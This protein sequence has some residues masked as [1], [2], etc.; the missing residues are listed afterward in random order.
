MM[1]HTLQ[2]GSI[3]SI[4]ASVPSAAV[5]PLRAAGDAKR[6]TLPDAAV[7]ALVA[8]TRDRALGLPATLAFY[9]EEKLPMGKSLLLI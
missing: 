6:P 9:D 2:D 5:T 7:D 8:A 4:P 1:Q 3:F